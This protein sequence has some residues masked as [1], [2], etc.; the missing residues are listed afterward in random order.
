M[1]D[2]QTQ[3]SKCSNQ[4]PDITL[5]ENLTS[6]IGYSELDN[7]HTPELSRDRSYKSQSDA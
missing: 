5:E 4:F 1:V 7:I 6:L 2:L 3:S